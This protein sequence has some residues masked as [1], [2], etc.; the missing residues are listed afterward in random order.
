[1]TYFVSELRW[2][3]FHFL[4]L[5]FNTFLTSNRV[6]AKVPVTDHSN[7]N[8]NKKLK[9]KNNNEKSQLSMSTRMTM[10]QA[11]NNWIPQTPKWNFNLHPTSAPPKRPHSFPKGV[12]HFPFHCLLPS[13][14]PIDRE[15]EQPSLI[16]DQ[17]AKCV[18]A[19]ISVNFAILWS[20]NGREWKGK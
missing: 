1:M 11:K 20:F 6:R 19:K 16:A 15:R 12:L 13:S 3:F 14:N 17:Y 9:N 5:A 4:F 2:H 18:R 8:N 7:N 10:K